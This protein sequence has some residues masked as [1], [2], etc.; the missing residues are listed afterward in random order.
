MSSRILLLMM[1]TSWCVWLLCVL[2]CVCIVCIVAIGTQGQAV[3]LLSD[4]MCSRRRRLACCLRLA[5]AAVAFLLATENT[6]FN[7]GP[8]CIS[9]P[10]ISIWWGQ[11]YL[12]FSKSRHFLLKCDDHYRYVTSTGIIRTR[13]TNKT[14]IRTSIRHTYWYIRKNTKQVE[15]LVER[16]IEKSTY[17]GF[18]P[19]IPKVYC[20]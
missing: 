15:L 4:V 17:N 11:R 19:T 18:L 20:C 12:S 8:L 16:L 3:Q 2:C 13:T 14:S 7:E 1:M 9:T 10:N 5:L 6:R